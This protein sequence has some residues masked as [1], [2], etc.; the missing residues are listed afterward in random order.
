MQQNE[1]IDIFTDDLSLLE[2]DVGFG[3]KSESNIKELRSFMDL[4]FSKNK[5]LAAI[6]WHP[7]KKGMVAVSAVSNCTYDE[8]VQAAE[9]VIYRN[10]TFCDTK[11]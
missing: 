5:A 9:Q 11:Y 8:R 1:T 3:M 2:D 7:R 10:L 6:D 4:E